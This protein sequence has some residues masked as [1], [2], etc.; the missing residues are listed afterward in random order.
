MSI[1]V[2]LLLFFGLRLNR[3]ELNNTNII[4]INNTLLPEKSE[5][6]EL[7]YF[8][9]TIEHIKHADMHRL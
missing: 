6:T 4:I 3:L 2:T 9:F 8:L 7:N 5:Q 1:Y